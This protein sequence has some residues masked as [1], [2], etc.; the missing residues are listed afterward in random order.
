MKN[1]PTLDLHDYHFGNYTIFETELNN[2]LDKFLAPHLNKPNFQVKIIVG[3][4]LNSTRFIN[5]KNPLRYYTEQYLDQ[6][7][8]E[9]S[10]SQGCLLISNFCYS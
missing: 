2:V 7:K 6:L 5:K 3:R 10:Y 9:Y 4:G 8:L 1:I